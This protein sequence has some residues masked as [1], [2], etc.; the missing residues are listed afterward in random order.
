MRLLLIWIFILAFFFPSLGRNKSELD[1]LIQTLTTMKEDSLKAK[2]LYEIAGSYASSDF[3]QSNKYY[4]QSESLSKKIGYTT[5]LAESLAG[6]A[7]N[8]KNP[9]E[10]DSAFRYN[11]LALDLFNRVKNR[12]AVSRVLGNIALVYKEKG[13][14]NKAIE[15]NFKSLS[16]LDE[17]KDKK[18]IA[19][20]QMNLGNIFRQLG[21]DKKAFEYQMLAL[22][23]YKSINDIGGM[24]KVYGNLGNLAKGKKE[25]ETAMQYYILGKKYRE[26]AGD[27]QGLAIIHQNIAGLYL[28]L[29]QDKL[30]EE[31]ALTALRINQ[32]MKSID[33]IAGSYGL[34]ADVYVQ[35]KMYD[36][37]NEYASQSLDIAKKI[38]S[39]PEIRSSYK[40]LATINKKKKD[41]KA[42]YEH[43]SMYSVYK[44][45]IFNDENSRQMNELEKKYQTEKKQKEIE[46]LKKNESIKDLEL[47]RQSM[48]IIVGVVVTII[49]V[50]F[51]FLIYRS[52]RQNKKANKLLTAQNVEIQKQK[53]IIEEKNKDIL[54]SIRYAEGL[55]NTI[56]PGPE[57]IGQVLGEAFVLFLPK[58][59][60]SGDFYW[61]QQVNDKGK[62]LSVFAV[63]DCTGHG[64]PGSI[65]SIV[66][67]NLLSNIVKEKM[68][69]RPE[70]IM[71]ELLNDLYE[72]LN[73]R[74]NQYTANDGMDIALCVWDRNSNLLQFSGAFNPLLIVR[75][76]EVVEFKAN[77]FSIGR[78]SK[79][80]NSVFTQTEI[81]LQK[82]DYIY[83]SSDGYA[84]QFGGE[85]S[86]KM[87]RKNFQ[88][89]ILNACKHNF[90]S[91]KEYLKTHFMGWKEGHEQVDDVCVMGIRV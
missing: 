24:G 76:G 40:I 72:A 56:L 88:Q 23:T 80:N 45:S 66:S 5:G 55:Q 10:Y 47:K 86:K 18:H 21:N 51:S 65:M 57:I 30:A 20:I 8:F 89:V 32:E 71:N 13:Q 34:L 17:K 19:R 29:D 16:L 9:G 82:G 11:Y 68:I 85:R 28:Q 3:D 39:K 14:Y 77:K 61:M 43:L 12:R 62:N 35:M 63:V 27:K 25:Y 26:Q 49:V 83:L 58:D 31:N 79:E 75:D 46:L 52:L 70:S 84:D 87:M 41:Y 78:H 15:F 53:S 6:M 44:D 69:Y 37:A 59:I 91:Q 2:R 73:K 42:A 36:K 1:S 74:G 33:G 60:V 38:G 48:A 7:T 50:F 54:D 81:Q 67:H 90:A 64:V 4:R 22:N